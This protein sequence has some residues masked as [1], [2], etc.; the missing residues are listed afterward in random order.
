MKTTPPN[1][2]DLRQQR[3]DQ[4][5]AQLSGAAQD[6][7]RS[8]R[9]QDEP[10]RLQDIA[11]RYD[12]I[13]RHA[14]GRLQSDVT[15]SEIL[16]AL[17]V[18]RMLRAKLNTDEALL[19][20]LARNEKVT[21][22]RIA[23]W[24]ETRHLRLLKNLDR[25]YEAIAQA[26]DDYVEA[27]REARRR[28]AERMWALENAVRIRRVAAQLAALEDLQHRV[29]H[30][31]EAT[32]VH[33]LRRHHKEEEPTPEPLTWPRALRACVAA[34]QQHATRADAGSAQHQKVAADLAYRLLGL[35][36]P[37]AERRSIDL[38]DHPDLA[39]AIVD[40]HIDARERI[41]PYY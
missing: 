29:D 40:L 18:T 8:A 24:T 20:D 11:D 23:E 15:A 25:S 33:V 26:Q 12:A 17:L 41:H 28:Q 32:L 5:W 16:A 19:T 36:R 21:W 1:E 9:D 7:G 38:S 10:L 22:A 2:E 37:A 4:A 34:A 3:R 31:S 6:E 27:L 30:S 35:T 14:E 13:C 39:D